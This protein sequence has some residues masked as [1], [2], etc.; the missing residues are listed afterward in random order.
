MTDI[1]TQ[2]VHAGERPDPVTGAIAT[3]I[4][5]TTAFA[6]GTLDH[7]AAL[8]SQEADGWTYSRWG[9]PTTAALQAKLAALEGGEAAAVFGA[10]TAAT[11]ALVRRPCGR[12]HS[13]IELHMPKIKRTTTAASRAESN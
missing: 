13:T 4:A 2:A 8:F 11:S 10:G 12:Y 9:N 7:G 6:Y 5:Q 1:R 3:G